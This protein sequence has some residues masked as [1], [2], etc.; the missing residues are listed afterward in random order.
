VL[1]FKIIINI[2]CFMLLGNRCLCMY[3]SVTLTTYCT[4]LFYSNT[5]SPICAFIRW[6][7]SSSSSSSGGGGVSSSSNRLI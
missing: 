1:F 4:D 7:S 3:L 6:S 5:V 2:E